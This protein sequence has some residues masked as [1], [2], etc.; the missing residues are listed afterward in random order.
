MI[1]KFSL[2]KLI[3][4]KFLVHIGHALDHAFNVYNHIERVLMESGEVFGF[5]YACV[6]QI[7][8]M[9]FTCGAAD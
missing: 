9:A 2:R 8:Q 4:M 5:T 7:Q 1:Q 3:L 6:R